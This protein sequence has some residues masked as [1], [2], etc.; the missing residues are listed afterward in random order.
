MTDH[1]ECVTGVTR[2]LEGKIRDPKCMRHL[3]ST[4]TVYEIGTVYSVCCVQAH[5]CCLGLFSHILP[6][7]C[8]VCAHAA[9]WLL[10]PCDGCAHAWPD[11]LLAHKT[12][13]GSMCTF[14]DSVLTYCEGL[15]LYGL[16]SRAT[17]WRG[18][19]ARISSMSCTRLAPCMRPGL[20][21]CTCMVGDASRNEAIAQT[22]VRV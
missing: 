15:L 17:T 16:S 20:P 18:P 12:C 19:G 13:V 4:M 22:L 3:T 6:V 8:T 7:D 9:T 10:G 2:F 5:G 14:S 1:H 11:V 21:S